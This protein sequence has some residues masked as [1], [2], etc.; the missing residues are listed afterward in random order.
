MDNH[1][2]PSDR[3]A[4]ERPRGILPMIKYQIRSRGATVCWSP[5]NHLRRYEC[6][7]TYAYPNT[8]ILAVVEERKELAKDNARLEAERI[9]ELEYDVVEG[10]DRV[11]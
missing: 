8:V 7:H 9:K 6:R 5:A 11:G 3:P 10:Q 4:G 1:S 2:G